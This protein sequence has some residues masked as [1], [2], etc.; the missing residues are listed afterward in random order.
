MSGS[1]RQFPISPPMEFLNSCQDGT[2]AI[3]YS[4][5]M[6]TNNDASVKFLNGLILHL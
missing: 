3:V 5:I 2:N 4:R 6:L 1:E